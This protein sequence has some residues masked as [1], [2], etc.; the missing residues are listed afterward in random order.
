ML[1]SVTFKNFAVFRDNKIEACPN[2][3][4]LI[5]RNS[6]GK[7]ILM[8]ILYSV[9][10]TISEYGKESAKENIA[11]ELSKKIKNNFLIER[12][13]KLA[14]R[15]VGSSRTEITMDL[16]EFYISFYFSTRS[17][18]VKIKE[19]K[20]RNKPT[21]AVYI[22]TKEIMSLMD[23]GFI[24]LY[25]QYH[26]MEEVYYD[27]A[28]K[29]DKPLPRGRSDK[30]V[31]EILKR[32]NSLKE[33]CGEERIDFLKI[34]REEGEF[35]TYKK[36]LG[37]LESKLV[38]EGYRKLMTL[39]YLIKS[40][41]FGRGR[42]FDGGEEF[43]RSGYLFWD[44]P[45][46]NLNPCMSR[47]VIDLLIDIATRLNTQIFVATHDYFIIKYF[48]LKHKELCNFDLK[49]YSLHFDKEGN[50]KVEE[51]DDLYALEHNSIIEEFEEV[52][53]YDVRVIQGLKDDKRKWVLL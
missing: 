32:T 19:L 9:I 49:F 31:D 35:Y 28:K 48:D 3:N 36:G 41:E 40:G 16:D 46:V 22:P 12:V 29:L 37:Y 45:E 43:G 14:T 4:V 5:G 8:K 33:T 44:E 24:G 6:T 30:I 11:Y 17:E 10:V 20:I 34:Y 42:E 2:I 7:S 15:R 53:R 13:G 39:S 38:A 18:K 26:F 51:S 27:L 1:K 21:G 50:L 52:Y 23:R 47:L 25:E